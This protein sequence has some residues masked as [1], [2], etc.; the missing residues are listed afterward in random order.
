LDFIQVKA[1]L[2][3]IGELDGDFTAH[4]ITDPCAQLAAQY[5]RQAAIPSNPQTGKP[6]LNARLICARGAA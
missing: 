1:Q 5:W 3:A 2:C 6:A 4:G